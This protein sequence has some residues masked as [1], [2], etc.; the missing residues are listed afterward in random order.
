[1]FSA[2]FIGRL[3]RDPEL[4]QTASGEL[5]KFTVAV[6]H[7]FGDKKTTSWV[8]C[9]LFGKQAVRA[10]EWLFKGG[11]VCVT[12]EVYISEWTNKEGTK[13]KDLACDVRGFENLDRKDPSH[14]VTTTTKYTT[15]VPDG[16]G[17]QDDDDDLPF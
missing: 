17:F 13:N 12:G 14:G 10:S 2:T 4:R 3:A 9:A 5:C 16:G 1:M 11:R 6:D 15:K 8:S 7:G